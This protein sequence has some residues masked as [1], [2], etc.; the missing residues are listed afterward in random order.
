[1]CLLHTAITENGK[2][3]TYWWLVRSVRCGRKVRQETVAR[4]GEL[5]DDGRLAARSFAVLVAGTLFGV[6]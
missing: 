6:P 2:Y 4:L 1:M 5:D 3:R